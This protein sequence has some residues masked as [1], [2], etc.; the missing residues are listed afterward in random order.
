MPIVVRGVFYENWKPAAT[1]Q[2]Y[3][4]VDEFLE[5]VANEAA[6]AGETEAS[7]ATTAVVSVLKRHISAGETRT[8]PRRCRAT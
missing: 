3:R 7:F 1:P 8:S 4:S 2:T 6:L 5:R